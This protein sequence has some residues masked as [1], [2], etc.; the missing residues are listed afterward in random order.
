SELNRDAP[1]YQ[2]SVEALEVNEPATLAPWSNGLWEDFARR[3]KQLLPNTVRI[4]EHIETGAFPGETGVK[5]PYLVDLLCSRGPIIVQCD[6][7]SKQVARSIVQNIV[8]RAALA[9]PGEV[10]FSLLD[11]SGFGFPFA[12]ALPHVR[13]SIGEPADQLPAIVSDIRR[14]NQ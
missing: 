9:S 13:P 5:A 1:E 2:A 11:S 14:I 10:R 3:P 6:A 8:L 12:A 7:A 4:G